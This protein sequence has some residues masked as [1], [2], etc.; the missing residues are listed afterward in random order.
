MTKHEKSHISSQATQTPVHHQNAL[1]TF[2]RIFWALVGNAVLFFVALGIF[3]RHADFAA[4][5]G[6]DLFYCVV[7]ALLAVVRY[8]DIK[9]LGG[10]NGEGHPASIKDW[11]TY[12]KFLLPISAG[13]WLAA[14]A[15]ASLFK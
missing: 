2:A 1:G 9:Y 8:C 4:F 12:V 14:H 10:L 5:S 7:A 15:A 11:I 3:Q 13:L 6:L